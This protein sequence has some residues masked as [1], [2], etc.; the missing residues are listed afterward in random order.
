M[1]KEKE[2]KNYNGFYSDCIQYN[3]IEIVKY[4]LSID[5]DFNK[6]DLIYACDINKVEIIRL[7]FGKKQYNV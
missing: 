3:R 6:D 5:I 1:I 4:L 2:L 7:L